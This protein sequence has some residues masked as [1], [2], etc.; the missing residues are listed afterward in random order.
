[1]KKILSLLFFIVLFSTGGN[2]QV[3]VQ[4]HLRTDI[5]NE[6][7]KTNKSTLRSS[8]NFS[9]DDIKFWVGDGSNQAA[10]VI[11]WH[12]GSSPDAMV[13]G[14]RWNGEAS[15]HD[16]IVAIA[17]ADP[18]LLLLTQYTGWMGY[19]IDG[20]G[21]GDAPY[22]N[23]NLDG[24]KKDSRIAFKFEPP[25]TN[26]LLGQTKFPE[27]PAEDV[28]KAISEGRKNGVIYHPINAEVYG[29]PSYDYDY[30]SC[31]SGAIHWKAGWY[32]GYWSYF[33]KDSQ[34]GSFSYSGLGA[35]SRKLTNGSWDAWSWN[36]DMTTSSGTSPSDNLVAAP[37]TR[38][39][40][41]DQPNNPTPPSI[42]VTGIK[43][44]PE[45]IRLQIGEERIISATISPVN[46][47]NKSI[48][49]S[50]S[51]SNIANIKDGKVV[52]TALGKAKIIVKTEDGGYMAICNVTVVHKVVPE[53][54]YEENS[55]ILSFPK[56]EEATSYEV[57]VFKYENGDCIKIGTYVADA[58]GNIIAE[59]KANQLISTI[60]L[61]SIRLNNIDHNI[62]HKIEIQVMKGLE[63]IETYN[64]ESNSSSVS[65]EFISTPMPKVY[66]AN[67]TLYVSNLK[68]FTLKM[69][70]ITGIPV[71][72]FNIHSSNEQYPLSISK[73]LYIIS[74]EKEKERI[75]F[76]MKIKH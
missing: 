64:V 38:G 20:I 5:K 17:K 21:Y 26:T 63:T 58:S 34:N 39:N 12:D 51:D 28:A 44:I 65:N 15:G 19:T 2:S 74:A 7:T 1:M 32:D 46:A 49:W 62:K 61:I 73:G 37:D 47:D 71:R 24:A 50:S 67:G 41:G 52:G 66:F 35:T 30:W 22:I 8:Q 14:Y 23:Y 72:S 43:I 54:T 29:Y 27:T 36:G 70:S 4:G 31:A 3:T 6:N 45:N 55:T 42:K 68:D 9:F 56:V 16:M 53:I 76:K 60:D 69:F 10:L 25:I 11:E 59:L 75:S 18:K 13:W 40:S 48:S 33:V 57:R